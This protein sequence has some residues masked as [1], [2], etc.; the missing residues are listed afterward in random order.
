MAN[1]ASTYWHQGRWSEAEKL[2]VE[3]LETRKTALGAKHPDTLSSMAN[4]A[5]T[6][7]NQGRWNE[8]EKLQVQ[9]LEISKAA[10]GA[11]HPNTLTSRANL[12]YTWKSQSRLTDALTLIEVC[13]Q[14][15]NKVLGLDHP[16]AR[17]S[18]SVHEVAQDR[19]AAITAHPHHQGHVHWPHAPRGLAT[20]L[21]LRDHPLIIASKA[22]SYIPGGQDL[23]K[24]N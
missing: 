18:T 24:V 2:E 5:S 6:Y 3:I 14:L 11:E 13:C 20:G 8:A 23:H 22:S 4:L 9:V 12:T 16:D 10:L 21:F 19:P 1:L 15:H 7:W 17:D